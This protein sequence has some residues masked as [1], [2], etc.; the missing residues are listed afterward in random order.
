[1]TKSVP[2]NK[3][4]ENMKKLQLAILAA[5]LAG[6]MSASAS[7]T[8]SG[9]DFNNPLL[10]ASYN[11]TYVAAPSG[12]MHLAYGLVDPIGDA[13]VGVRGPLGTLNSLSMS[14][15]YS[16]PIGTGNAPF[17]AFGVSVDGLW[18]SGSAYEY[19]II[20]ENG[21]QLIGTSLVHVWDWNLNGGAGGDVPGLSGVTLN[22]ILGVGNSYNSVAFGN[23]QVM[24]AY[25]YIGDTGGPSSGSVDINSITVGAYEVPEPTT[26][27]AGA[28]LL[29]PF[30]ASTIRMLRKSRTA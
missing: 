3:K 18:G 17:A 26:M 29:L 1:L 30:G 10:V 11:G 28:L 8:I 9:S 23:L 7:V 13:V 16:N 14:F 27:V 4:K 24:R 2:N 20:S 19:N 22:S 21:N 12:H 6:A 5:G 25:A 15:Q